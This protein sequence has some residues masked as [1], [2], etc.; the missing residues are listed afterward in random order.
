MVKCFRGVVYVCLIFVFALNGEYRKEVGRCASK[1]IDIVTNLL[2]PSLKQRLQSSVEALSEAKKATK[3]EILD[4]E[5]RLRE[6][7]WS[8]SSVNRDLKEL[9]NAI[10]KVKARETIRFLGREMIVDDGKKVLLSMEGE[11]NAL[12]SA[13]QK[14]EEA[15]R[16]LRERLTEQ[17]KACQESVFALSIA[18]AAMLAQ[19]GAS[20]V[21]RNLALVQ[22]TEGA[23]IAGSDLA[24]LSSDA[25]HEYYSRPSG[26]PVCQEP[27][28]D[29]ILDRY[30]PTVIMPKAASK[31]APKAAPKAA[32]KAASKEDATSNTVDDSLEFLVERIVR[33]ASM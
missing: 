29:D 14:R 31:D 18:D 6:N 22:E 8:L 10:R 12:E 4:Q 28:V 15:I 23:L 5:E 13:V 7:A 30:A 32:S 27:S 9:A 16:T 1:G 25:I 26:K 33:A 11:R 21:T 3:T 24:D 19:T 2:S 17:E 20:L